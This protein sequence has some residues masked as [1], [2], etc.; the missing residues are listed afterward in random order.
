[1]RSCLALAALFLALVPATGCLAIADGI[2]E[3][4]IE[5]PLDDLTP[6]F[7]GSL[8]VT[9]DRGAALADDRV[10][11]GVFRS[12]NEAQELTTLTGDTLHEDFNLMVNSDTAAI[13]FWTDAV[14]EGEIVATAIA[15]VEL[16]DKLD[17]HDYMISMPDPDEDAYYVVIAWY[18]ADGDG[19][20]DLSGT[21]FSETARPIGK[22]LEFDGD[23]FPMVLVDA[24]PEGDDDGWRGVAASGT[25]FV[26]YRENWVSDSETE[27][28]H[29]ELA[30]TLE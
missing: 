2:V 17:H 20:L 18:D 23:M 10:Q 22:D 30:T 26:N 4:T 29:A 24:Q 3:K 7:D 1:M 9:I 8:A 11:L 12:V 5:E 25:L 14:D 21:G 16:G 19:L 28:W 27:G 6:S 15:P 13:E